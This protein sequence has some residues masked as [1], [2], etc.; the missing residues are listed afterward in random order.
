MGAGFPD[1]SRARTGRALLAALCLVSS[2]AC[3]QDESLDARLQE[4]RE[5]GRFVPPKA[6]AALLKL[7]PEARAASP[8]LKG[9][10]LELLGNARRGTGNNKVAIQLADE[11]LTFGRAQKDKV[12]I[13]KGLLGQAYC[14]SAAN[15]LTGS[16]QLAWEAEKVANSTADLPLRI[17]AT[18]TSGQSYSE[19]GNFPAALN[20]LQAAVNLARQYGQP[21]QLVMSLNSL[22]ALY[23][24]IKEYDK[25]F[26][27]L[28]EATT[29]A[30]KTNSPGRMSTLKD[31][32]YALAIDSNQPERGLRALLAGLEYERQIG[33]ERMM[34]SSYVNLADSY[35]K[36][37][38]YPRTLSYSNQAIEL[39]TK[40]ND[41]GTVAT[42]RI[43]IGQAYLGMGRLAE[44][45]R[46]FEAGMDWYKQSGDKPE[47]QE[48]MIE[49]GDALERAGDLSGALKAY[50]RERE[51]SNEL[52]E[53]RRQKATME[54]QAKYEADRKQRQI[55][56]LSREIEL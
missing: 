26:A 24:Q 9:E 53:Q 4:I 52:F 31:T 25:G 43:N 14:A 17:R 48:V 15:D 33:A 44:G 36:K 39:A 47:L 46:S 13:A 50:H 54:L 23:R 51:I 3:A 2:F 21:I 10:F 37:R 55:E 5:I 6:L 22:A 49:Y 19:D 27:A 41:T 18:I 16:H 42:A 12:L 7:E 38:D 40:L 32:E 56:L 20:K 45:K 11:L 8:A 29:A 35:L 1:I 28:A 30:E 34:S